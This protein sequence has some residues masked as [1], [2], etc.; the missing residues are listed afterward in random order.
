MLAA[1]R[2][3]GRVP[4]S[5]LGLSC[6]RVV[7]AEAL[8]PVCRGEAVVMTDTSPFSVQRD[9]YTKSVSVIPMITLQTL[10]AQC[11]SRF[12]VMFRTEYAFKAVK[13][14]GITSIAVRGKDSVCVVTQKKVTVGH[15]RLYLC[16][17]RDS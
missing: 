1:S 13:A 5:V 3:L 10:R 17:V 15:G 8:H 9:D 2:K 12:T 6:V 11:V 16:E 7:F 4:G 14:A